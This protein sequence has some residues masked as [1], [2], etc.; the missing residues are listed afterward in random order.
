MSVS[1]PQCGQT[2]PLMFS[3]KPSTGM[4][5]LSNIV[6]ALIASESATSCGVVTTTAPDTETCW[7][8]VS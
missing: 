7:A 4:L 5:T 2:K 6:F 1:W 3:T 8:M